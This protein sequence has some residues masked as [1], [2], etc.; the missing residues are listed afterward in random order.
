MKFKNKI[1]KLLPRVRGIV[2]GMLKNEKKIK[3]ENI[4]KESNEKYN[5]L[6]KLNN[7]D[8]SHDVIRHISKKHLK[9]I[10][11]ITPTFDVLLGGG[12]PMG[13]VT[14]I[15]GVSGSGKTQ[16]CMQILSSIYRSAITKN[17][18][19]KAIYIGFDIFSKI[20]HRKW[21]SCFATARNIN[22]S[23]NGEYKC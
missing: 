18:N 16:I 14:E 4:I 8:H 6:L 5:Y 17:K 7:F 15:C 12:I 22:G 3:V 13:I 20:R 2:R 9:F 1:I 23:L 10:S 19:Y 21:V 11:L